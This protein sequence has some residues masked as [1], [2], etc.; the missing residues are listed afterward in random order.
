[1]IPRLLTRGFSR[2]FSR[3][4]SDTYRT[5][6]Y[7]Y[8]VPALLPLA[9]IAMTASVYTTVITCLDRYI[10]I[11]RPGRETSNDSELSCHLLAFSFAQFLTVSS[12]SHTDA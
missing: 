1:M 11:C 9:Q 3:A 4:L 10:A 5:Y 8:T 7:P 12:R 2:T 6:V